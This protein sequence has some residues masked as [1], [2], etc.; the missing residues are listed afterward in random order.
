[1]QPIAENVSSL[2]FPFRI[3]FEL[4]LRSIPSLCTT[5]HFTVCCKVGRG[6]DLTV[7]NLYSTCVLRFSDKYVYRLNTSLKF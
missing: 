3:L 4:L 6:A 7:G 2:E 5:S 1:M